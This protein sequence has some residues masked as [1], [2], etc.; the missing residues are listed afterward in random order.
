M[1]N[2]LSFWGGQPCGKPDFLR[3]IG[4]VRAKAFN[5]RIIRQSFK[6]RGI[7]PVNGQRIVD[8][9]ASTL[10]F[11]PLYA[12]DLRA[13]GEPQTPSPEPTDLLSSSVENTPP[14]SIEALEKNHCQPQ[15]SLLVPKQG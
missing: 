10:E 14:K 15:W 2:E 7:W 12:P 11:T 4:P 5:P 1:N 8:K 6:D 13:Y 9:L 3:V